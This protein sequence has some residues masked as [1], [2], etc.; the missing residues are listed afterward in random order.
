[1]SR[2]VLVVD[3]QSE[4]R[5][6]VRMVMEVESYTVR[7]AG[8]AS[9]ALS[10]ARAERP[11][12]FIIDIRMPGPLDGLG[13]CRAIRLDPQLAQVPVILLTAFFRADE[14]HQADLAGA[15]VFFEKPFNFN[16]L[17]EQVERLIE[18]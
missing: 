1:M 12:C 18:Q 14:R 15:D 13:L 8:N 17:L 5:Q 11:D 3:D 9:L 2:S 7:E 16:D 10:L 6:L 4:A